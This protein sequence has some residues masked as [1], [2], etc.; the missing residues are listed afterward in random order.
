MRAV[1]ARRY[2]SPEVLTVEDV[3]VPVPGP[4]QV[5]VR[6]RAA[7]VNPADLRTLSG[8]LRELTPLTFPH[9]PGSDFAG[10]VT[11][12]GPDVTRFA[13]GDE[14]FGVGLPRATAAMAAM[15]STPPSLTTGAMAEYA[16]F[17]ADTPALARRPVA[18]VPEHAAGLPIPGLTALAVLREGG[19]EAGERVL[20]SGA[21]GGVGGALVPLLAA[22]G[23]HVIATALPE[24]DDHVRGLG[25]AELVDYRTLDT[26]TETL[27][28]H[29]DGVDAVVNLALPE[30]ELGRVVKP[31][32][33]LLNVAFPSPD[34]ADFA[35]ADLTVRTVYGTARPGD[36]DL[37][38][39]RAVAGGL[40]DTTGRRYPLEEAPRAYSDLVH[41]HVRGKLV[42]L[43][44]PR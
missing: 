7:A 16:V 25:A 3:P 11:A 43:V 6:V 26:A 21:A 30:P 40:P 36:L 41:T 29:P 17:E 24:D 33:R 20:V 12:V 42:V 28:R 4:C 22:A 9:V 19:F 8:V 31:G 34:P 44:D 1:V 35:R 5:Q 15:L 13:V 37:L 38:A 14:V 2:G 32:G 23:V 39:A 10:T 27:R 18:L